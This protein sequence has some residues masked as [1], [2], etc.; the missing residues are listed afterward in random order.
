M[1]SVISRIFITIVI[2]W[3]VD[4]WVL[5]LEWKRKNQLH[6]QYWLSRVK[7]FWV[8]IIWSLMIKT[9]ANFCFFRK[10]EKLLW[11]RLKPYTVSVK[12]TSRN[13][14]IVQWSQNVSLYNN[15]FVV[16]QNV[17]SD[18]NSPYDFILCSFNFR[19]KLVSFRMVHRMIAF[20][21]ILRDVGE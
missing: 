1:K 2:T 12:Y 20:D 11:R 8:H 17:V 9:F 10:D 19:W 14:L 4:C 3:K 7:N 6:S 5:T 21:E 16:Q 15:I 18:A 13:S